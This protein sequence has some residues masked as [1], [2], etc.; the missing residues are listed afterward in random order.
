VSPYLLSVRIHVFN[1][2]FEFTVL[3]AVIIIGKWY[4]PHYVFNGLFEFTVLNAVII[5]GK[6]YFPHYVTNFMY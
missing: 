5:I 4:F 1:G 2:L 6:W 3:N